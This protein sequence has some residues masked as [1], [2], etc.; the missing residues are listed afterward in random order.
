MVGAR[1]KTRNRVI[2]GARNASAAPPSPRFRRRV[3]GS[4]SAGFCLVPPGRGVSTDGHG[5]RFQQETML[6]R[7]LCMF[8]RPS[9]TDDS[10]AKISCRWRRTVDS[11][12]LYL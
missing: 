3:R 11:K 4:G 1:T 6:V 9:E 2:D 8:L 7:S 5:P 10:P 12:A